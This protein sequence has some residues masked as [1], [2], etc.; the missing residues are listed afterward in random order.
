MPDTL[1][2]GD[3]TFD[4]A[5]A[6]LWGPDGSTI[7]LRSQSTRV[8]SVLAHR[9][10]TLVRREEL[11]AAVWSGIAV[12]D[13]SLVQCIRDIRRAL[14]D[15]GHEIVKTVVG[16]GYVLTAV[17]S[18]E[19]SA[20]PAVHLRRFEARGNQA[21]ASELSAEIEDAILTLLSPRDALSV[22]IGPV[23]PR[24]TAYRIEGT[25]RVTDVTADARF[26]ILEA[27]TG[28]VVLADRVSGG[29]ATS[30][31]LPRL[32]AEAL[33]ARLRVHM[34]VH[35]GGAV[36]HSDDAVLTVQHLKEKAAWHMARFQ[37]ENWTAAR[38]A[39]DRACA[40]APDDPV[41]LAMQASMATQMIPL[42]P[43]ADLGDGACLA[44]ARADRAVELGHGVDYVLRTR[45]NIRL[46]RFRDHDGA[47]RDCARALALN[48]AFHLAH[49]TCATSEIL[50]GDPLSGVT[51][52]KEIMRRTPVDTQNPLYLSLIAIG[53][54]LL[55]DTG[56]AET[57][58]QE[59]FD[60]WP[61]TP[62]T[63]MVLAAVA[64]PERLAREGARLRAMQGALPAHHF[65]HMPFTRP[66]DLQLLED[67]LAR[68]GLWTVG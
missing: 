46:W 19:V 4:T 66:A 20:R 8:L 35:E 41:A 26:R 3:R 21:A 38:K 23:A 42:L 62:W 61:N 31:D 56:A 55:N 12:T 43:F 1:L 50:S 7:D 48:P 54:R 13:D 51:R 53:A 10:G 58:A 67:G 14:A 44:L 59:A 37:R 2:L 40:L 16:R 22:H 45:G 33:A 5:E 64:G 57:A 6:R 39:L 60:L 63:G 25:V 49:L 11:I 47:R 17:Q 52:L 9:H 28:R 15:D 29:T 30:V 24:K 18:E 32:V 34:I 36:A 65:R 27:G 68:S